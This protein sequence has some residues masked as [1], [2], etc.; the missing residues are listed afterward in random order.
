M[1]ID[2]AYFGS[3]GTPYQSYGDVSPD[4]AFTSDPTDPNQGFDTGAPDPTGGGVA[5]PTSEDPCASLAGDPVSYA[6]C[7]RA[8]ALRQSGASGASASSAVQTAPAL[9]TQ[10]LSG[11]PNWLPA[12]S[13][14][15]WQGVGGIVAGA[16]KALGKAVGAGIAGAGAPGL[17]LIAIVVGVIVF[18]NREV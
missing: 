12:T 8:W 5:P 1:V 11:L 13:D 16:A 17:L 4:P 9:G 7:Q 18:V 15:Y 2:T 14:Q 6:Q 10:I 3:G